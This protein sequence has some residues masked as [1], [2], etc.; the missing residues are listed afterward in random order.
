MLHRNSVSYTL[1]ELVTHLNTL[2]L[3]YF[4]VG[5]FININ[6]IHSMDETSSMFEEENANVSNFVLTE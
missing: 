4:G 3:N 6:F 1:Y 2:Q 5:P